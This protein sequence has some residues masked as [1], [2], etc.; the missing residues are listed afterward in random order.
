MLTFFALDIGLGRIRTG[1]IDFLD[2]MH[3]R[4]TSQSPHYS[5]SLSLSRQEQTSRHLLAH[6]V[7]ESQ[8]V[9]QDPD[10]PLGQ[11]SIASQST[12]YATHRR[13]TGVSH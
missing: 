4:F 3:N 7:R 10:H 12:G 6:L 5:L 11:P 1:C 8:P 9:A 13:V 2:G